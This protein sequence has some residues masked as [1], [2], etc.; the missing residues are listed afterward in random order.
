VNPSIVEL[1][2]V[3]RGVDWLPWAVQ[4]S[5]LIGLSVGAFLLALPGLVFER[6]AWR[7]C[8]RIALLGSLLCGLTAPVALLSDL[9]QP[10][11]FLH[12][13]LSPN[14]A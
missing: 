1:V 8:P 4:Y 13:Y 10:G 9:H 2:H 3:A 7:D 5:L 12:F 14:P 11:R 6:P